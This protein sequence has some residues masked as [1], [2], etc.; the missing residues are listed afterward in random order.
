MDQFI[1]KHAN[2]VIGTLSG[3]DRL[4]FRGT[5]RRLA[6]S[7]GMMSYLW[8]M[9]ILL[10]DFVS[11]AETLTRRLKEASADLA[12]RTSRPIRYLPSSGTSKEQIAREIARSDGITEGLICVLTAVE[13]CLS[14]EIVRDRESKHLKLMPRHRKCL[15]LY[16]YQIHPV[17]GFM[18]ARIQTWFP[19][20]I[21]ICIN[22]REWLARSMDAEGIGYVQ[23]ENCFTWIEDPVRVQHLMDQQVKAAWPDLLDAVA[24]GLNPLHDEMFQACP[25]DY[26]WSTY[27]SEWATDILFQNSKSLARLYPKLVHHGLTTFLSPDVMRFLGRNIP[28]SGHVPP[29]LKAEVASDMKTRPE[30]VRIKHRLGGNSIKMYDKQGSVLRIE[31]TINDAAGFKSFRTPEGKPDAE[32]AW[33]TMRKGI[34]D[35]HRRAEVSQAANGRYLRALASVEDTT[36]LGELTTKLAQPVKRDGRRARPFNPHAPDDAKLIEAISRGEFTINGFRNRDLRALLY[37]DDSAPREQQRRHAAAVSRKLALLRAHRLIR[38]VQGTHRYHLT[39]HGRLIVT[40][41]IGIRNI[42]T[43]KVLQLAA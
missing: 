4:V 22:G 26:Y 20:S 8:A 21:Q 28:P 35:L 14:Y 9:G 19:F 6:H 18:H 12:R 39:D 31:T 23:R 42:G 10:K 24:R 2:A 29:Q 37:A 3:F 34:A 1:S 43:S 15:F 25:I 13:P 5:L 16:H 41:L 40:A 30:G 38:K 17:F 7:G 11:H 32:P 33:H 36:S 27:Q